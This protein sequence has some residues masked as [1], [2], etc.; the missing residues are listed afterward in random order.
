M[1]VLI[2]QNVDFKVLNRDT[3][4][5]GDNQHEW[6]DVTL[7]RIRN[8]EYYWLVF[9]GKTSG[10]KDITKKYKVLPSYGGEQYATALEDYDKRYKE[11]LKKVEEQKRQIRLEEKRIKEERANSAKIQKKRRSLYRYFKTESFGIYNCDYFY[12]TKE[13]TIEFYTEVSNEDLKLSELHM[14]DASR[15]RTIKLF[16]FN[17]FQGFK[18]GEFHLVGVDS[19]GQIVYAKNLSTKNLDKNNTLSLTYTIAD[20]NS[21]EEFSKHLN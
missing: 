14:I 15:N 1:F 8:Q 20:V 6:H 2:F 3:Y 17:R 5:K 7:N 12:N 4:K 13:E 10:G 21:L 11:Y 9:K 19:E 18:D 16:N